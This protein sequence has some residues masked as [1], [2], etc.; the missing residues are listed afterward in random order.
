MAMG[1]CLAY[2]VNFAALPMSPGSDQLSLR[3][4]EWTFP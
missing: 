3:W 4:P 2:N 1:E